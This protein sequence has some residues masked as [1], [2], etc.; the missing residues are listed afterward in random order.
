MF[1][2]VGIMDNAVKDGIRDSC[3]GYSPC[4]LVL[5]YCVPPAAQ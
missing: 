2:P 3:C 4:R 1:D 5:Y